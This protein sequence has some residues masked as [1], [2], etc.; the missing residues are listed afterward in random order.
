MFGAALVVAGFLGT[1]AGGRLGDVLQ[2]KHKGGYFLSSGIG[3]LLGIPATIAAVLMQIPWMYWTGI[4]VALFFLFFNTG[5]LN[6]A[7]VNVVPASM[8]A[9]AVAVNVLVIHLL[10]DALSPPVIGKIS[11]AS[12]LSTAVL[13]NSGVIALAAVIL[14]AGSGALKWDVERI[15]ASRT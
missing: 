6:A 7:L 13:V 5:P 10:G 3:L 9:S 12:S 2:A 14:L 11:D 4:F 1:L 8:R 15:P